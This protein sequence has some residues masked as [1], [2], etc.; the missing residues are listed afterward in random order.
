LRV[1]LA[2]ICQKYFLSK[3]YMDINNFTA[4]DTSKASIIITY[5]FALKLACKILYKFSRSRKQRLLIL[6]CMN[7]R[8]DEGNMS[9]MEELSKL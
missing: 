5:H 4:P 6:V 2:K 7:Q 8:G 9:E 1:L 3:R